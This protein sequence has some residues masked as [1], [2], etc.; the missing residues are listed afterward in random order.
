MGGDTLI[1]GCVA[2]EPHRSSGGRLL[3]RLARS[4]V[5]AVGPFEGDAPISSFYFPTNG[6]AGP[7][8]GM[9][10]PPKFD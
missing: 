5:E 4:P 10:P 8:E 9:A 7:P 3:G 1:P 6:G 2:G